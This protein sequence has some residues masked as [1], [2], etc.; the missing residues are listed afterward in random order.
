MHFTAEYFNVFSIRR[1]I[2]SQISDLHVSP[3]RISELENFPWP[4]NPSCLL[5]VAYLSVVDRNGT[6]MLIW[7]ITYQIRIQINPI[8]TSLNFQM[9]PVVVILVLKKLHLRSSL[10][11]ILI[12]H[13]FIWFI[14]L[15]KFCNVSHFPSPLICSRRKTI[16][17]INKRLCKLSFQ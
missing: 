3:L 2:F 6:P 12:F 16:P 13:S 14:H 15:F 7:Y 10:F 11:A 4:L 1:H 8:H 5:F 17:K 9:R